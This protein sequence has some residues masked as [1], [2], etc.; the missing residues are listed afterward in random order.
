M[1]MNIG[2]DHYMHST[3]INLVTINMTRVYLLKPHQLD[4]SSVHLAFHSELL[5]K[6][7]NQTRLYYSEITVIFNSQGHNIYKLKTISL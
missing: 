4:G 1:G 2:F 3:K 5:C 6:S 7:M